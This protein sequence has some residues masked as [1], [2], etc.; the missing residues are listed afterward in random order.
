MHTISLTLASHVLTMS[1]PFATCPELT[2][3]C[4]GES[5]WGCC[6]LRTISLPNAHH[7]L[8]I[9]LRYAACSELTARCEGIRFGVVAVCVQFPDR[10]LIMS[11]PISLPIDTCPRLTANCKGEPFRRRCLK[12]DYA[13]P[14]KYDGHYQKERPPFCPRNPG[15]EISEQGSKSGPANRPSCMRFIL[16]RE[17][18]AQKR[19]Q[20]T[21]SKSVRLDPAFL[22]QTCEI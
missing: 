5:F 13:T 12:S 8:T 16:S 10:L 1:S 4:A 14:Q 9:S 20:K 21:G 17:F 3:R 18:G 15:Q 22:S 7:V 19:A 11:L 2:A 6:C